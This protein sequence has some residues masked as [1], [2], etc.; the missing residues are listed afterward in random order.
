MPA[1]T[2]IY[3]TPSANPNAVSL[4]SPQD[5]WFE[6]SLS[7]SGDEDDTTTGWYYVITDPNGTMVNSEF[8][9]SDTVAVGQANQQGARIDA[10][11]FNQEGI[12]WIMLMD[13]Q[14]SSVGG[15]TVEVGP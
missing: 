9:P 14:G 13:P 10:G 12:W 5:V 15:A 8:A 11:T 7:N 1:N 6:W 2:Q 4:S 3:G